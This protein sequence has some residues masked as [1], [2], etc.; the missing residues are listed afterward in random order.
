MATYEELFPD[1][2]AEPFAPIQTGRVNSELREARSRSRSALDLTGAGGGAPDT[3]FGSAFG[4]LLSRAPSAPQAG[5]ETQWSDYGRA[6]VAGV[7]D[8]GTAATGAGEYLANRVAGERST[9][10]EQGFGDLADLFTSGRHSSQEFAQSW[11]DSM[12]PEARARSEREVMTL[13]PNQTIWQGSP[14]EFLS[15]VGLKLARSAPSTA[16]TLLPGALIMRA[17]LGRGALVYLGASEGGM[18][19][20]SIAAN[21]AQE[22]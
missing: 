3:G 2:P 20:G 6:T 16:V 7:G 18:S 12:T 4:D 9:P 22:V 14:S 19:L 5:G 8:L 1:Q 21:I 10:F 11:Y 13:D 17:G 15:S